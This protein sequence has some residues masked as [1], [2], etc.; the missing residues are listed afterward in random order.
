M[1]VSLVRL[2]QL[3][4]P[5][6]FDDQKNAAAIAGGEASSVDYADFQEFV[7]SQ[8]KRI[9][10]GNAA[11][12]WHDDIATVHGGDASLKALYDATDLEE[13]DFLRWKLNLQDIAVPGAQAYVTLTNAGDP[14]SEVIAIAVAT[15]GAVSAQ[16]AGAVGSAQLTELS[17]ESPL[18]P[19][20]LVSIFD[21]TSGDPIMSD[22]RRVWGLLQ[23]GSAATDGNNF[24][25]TGNDLGQI[26]FVRQ[27]ATFDDLELCPAADIGGKSINYAYTVRR[28]LANMPEDAL[29]GD[30]SEADQIA[31][32][33][34]GLDSAYDGGHFI[35]VDGNDID[36]RLADTKSFT[37]RKSGGNVLFTVLRTDAGSA[38][39]VQV[40]GDVD[41]FDVDAADNDF[42]Q[43]VKV[44][45][46]DQAINVGVTAVGVIDSSAIELRATTGA[47]EVAAPSGNVQFQTVRETTALPLDDATT[48]AIS[49]LKTV[50]EGSGSFV[51]VSDALK[52]AMEK[53]GVDLGLNVFVAGANYAQG[54]NIPAAT[55]DLTTHDIDM[56]TPANVDTFLFLNGRLLYGGNVTT[57]NDVYPGTT[58]AN[59]DL[60]VDFPKGVKSGDVI[61]SIALQQ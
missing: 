41:L 47:A 4:K 53:G 25:L 54:V 32:G 37:I 22:D 9:I 17:G 38:D 45:T 46:A 43:G 60:K 30:L 49:A 14:P 5:D 48:G 6:T 23:V 24:A 11:G 59:G 15:K 40:T 44:D 35:E 34:G 58:P 16:L 51:S 42:A 26:T 29:R 21:A 1:T 36:I 12:N 10:W 28:D 55:F 31:A 27:N 19:K 57:K 52:Y 50:F 39:K 2:D 3:Y 7:L 18:K 61:I 13:K 33:F 56:N 8:I 20:N